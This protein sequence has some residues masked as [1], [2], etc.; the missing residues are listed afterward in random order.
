MVTESP[1]LLT[2][3]PLTTTKATKVA[4]LRDWG[5]RDKAFI[6]L[7]AMVRRRLVD[8]INGRNSYTCIPLAGTGTSAIEAMMSTFIHPNSHS[9]LLINGAYGRRIGKILS[10]ANKSFIAVELDESVP[11]ETNA[12]VH[13]LDSNSSIDN[14]ILVH[15]ETTTGL[16]NPLPEISAIAKKRKKKLFVDAMS[17]FGA[18]SIDTSE[19]EVDAIAA[20]SNKCLEGVPGL[21]FVLAKEIL[22]NKCAGISNSLTLDLHDQ[23][24]GLEGNGQWRFTPPTQVVAA[25]NTAL[26]LLD[27]EGGIDQ[28]FERYTE[29][30]QILVSG[31][32]KL[33]FHT[34]L[35]DQDQ[36]P[37]I[38]T[39]HMP[40]D[41]NFVFQ[42][43][44]DFLSK[45]GFLIYPAKL[46][47]HPSFRIGCIGNVMRKDFEHLL[48]TIENALNSLGVKLPLEKSFGKEIE[49]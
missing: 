43:F 32:R 11:F 16:L 27:N 48:R 10:L 35:N 3:G 38:V 15:C 6:E 9:L 31:M 39:F 29:N 26:D 34:Y 7:T 40:K 1:L 33:G 18:I 47:K 45:K 23:W 42:E 24:Q 2:P 5:S 12:V 30:C 28:R 22:L 25:L 19:I 8:L 37:I 36:A 14:I 44:Y 13:L 17:S 49:E 41:T 4:M 46:T 21:A 20:S